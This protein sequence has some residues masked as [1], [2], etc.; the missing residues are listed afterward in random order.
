MPE[1]RTPYIDN[2]VPTRLVPIARQSLRLILAPGE[3]L[4]GMFSVIRFRRSISLLVV[5]DRRLLTLGDEHVGAPLVDEV[6]RAEVRE[7]VVERE[8][9]WSTGLVT[10]HTVHGDKVNLGT[11]S[12]TS[13]T[14]FLSLEEV[15]ARPTEPSL[16]TIPTP[17]PD[18]P[19]GLEDGWD[20]PGTA[21]VDD[22]PAGPGAGGS[23]RHPL[24][25]HL[26]ALADLHDR[27]ALTDEEFA[28]AKQRLLADP[29]GSTSG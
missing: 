7:V 3:E 25:E 15:L 29:E 14:T 19:V 23:P 16:P 13:S 27:G 10:A 17:G 22:A 2:K 18:L 6:P 12:S 26:T 21:P 28:T 1:E 5:T 9:V 8:K 11:L 24:V 20:G 4:F